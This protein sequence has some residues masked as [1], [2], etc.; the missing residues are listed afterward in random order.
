MEKFKLPQRLYSLDEA[1]RI[2]GVSK[3]YLRKVSYQG[4]FPILSIG[5]RRLLKSTVVE[6]IMNGF[7]DLTE[8]HADTVDVYGAK[9][10]MTDEEIA[11]AD[12]VRKKILENEELNNLEDDIFKLQKKLRIKKRQARYEAKKQVVAELQRDGEQK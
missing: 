11:I 1:S 7:V 4:F 6:D 5:G 3:I 9:Q 12:K 2:I 10:K 8:A